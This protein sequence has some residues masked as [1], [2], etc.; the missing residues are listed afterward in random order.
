MYPIGSI[1][2]TTNKIHDDVV[3]GNY[4]YISCY[5]HGCTFQLLP[6]NIF[7]KNI[8]YSVH[9]ETEYVESG[10]L[11]YPHYS[12]HYDESN[13]DSVCS[14]GGSSSHTHTTSGH[15]LTVDEIPSHNHSVFG[16]HTTT[17]GGNN[18]DCLAIG[19]FGSWGAYE[20]VPQYHESA[21]PSTLISSTGGGQSHS[22]GDTGSSSNVPPYFTVYMYK[23]T[24]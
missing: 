13:N 24:A 15:T 10:W 12:T 11:T 20:N 14:T 18:Q 23:R 16:A 19:R 7:L 9:N 1:Y 22:H 21:T 3:D 17:D 8:D 4:N 6:S 5:F 2:I